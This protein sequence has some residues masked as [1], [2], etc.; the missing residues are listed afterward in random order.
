[1]LSPLFH[2]NVCSLSKNLDDLQHLQLHEKNF[3]V[4]AISEARIKKQ[5]YLLNNVNLN[6]YSFKFT[7]TET[8]AG[9]TLLYI[10]NHQSYKPCNDLNIYKKN[11]L[12]ITFIEIV[13]LKK[14]SVIV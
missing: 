4:I 6:N 1:M 2:I 14:S 10:V 13:N 3:D 8:S 12:E 7:P 11:E 9:A 5:V